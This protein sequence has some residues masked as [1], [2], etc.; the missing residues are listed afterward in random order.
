MYTH[1][2]CN[3]VVCNPGYEVLYKLL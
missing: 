1:M 3:A 2:E